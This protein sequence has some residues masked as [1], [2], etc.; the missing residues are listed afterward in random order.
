MVIQPQRFGDAHTTKK[1][2]V[3]ASYL[4]AF[5]TALK[6]QNFELIYFDAC[7][8]SGSSVPKSEEER[9]GL[10]DTDAITVGSAIRAL[11]VSP[12]FD[13]YFF[14]DLRRK[15]IKSLK[16]IVKS[17]FGHLQD[18]VKT[19]HTDAND[20]LLKLCQTVNWRS[21]RAVVFLDPYGLQI[22]FSTLKALAETK[23]VD[24]WY[25][26]P[27]H[28]MSRQVKGDGT[29]LDDGGRSVDEALGSEK[30]RDVVQTTDDSVTDLFGHSTSKVT[31]AVDA[32]WFEK[33]AIDQLRTVFQGGVLE[34]T[35]PLGRNG[36]HEFSLMFAWANP[37]E[38]AK[39]AAKLA[40]A[41]LK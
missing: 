7:A 3:V 38:P 35:L 20:A 28:A 37:S 40:K 27:V 30:W 22:K 9:P 8:G 19:T 17:D 26:V 4:K 36:L 31:K 1:L 29:V 32:G 14:N 21:S 12:A 2:E 6:R 10:L 24:V 23:G 11:G 39:L 13:K 25:L 41:V 15:N 18:R 33:F 5:T 34:E 16:A